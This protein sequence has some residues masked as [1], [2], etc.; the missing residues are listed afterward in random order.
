MP[1]QGPISRVPPEDPQTAVPPDL[2]PQLQGKPVVVNPQTGQAIV[3][4][5]GQ[6]VDGKTMQPVIEDPIDIIRAMKQS[7]MEEEWLSPP[8]EPPVRADEPT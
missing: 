4:Y 5:N 6:W 2:N 1:D 3:L 7:V 8:K